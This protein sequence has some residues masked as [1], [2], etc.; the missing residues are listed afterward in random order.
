MI[1]GNPDMCPNNTSPYYDTKKSQYIVFVW[2]IIQIICTKWIRCRTVV[3]EFMWNNNVWKW[4]N[5]VRFGV[6]SRVR[7][8][9]RV[10][11]N[12]FRDSFSVLLRTQYYSMLTLSDFRTYIY[13]PGLCD[14]NRGLQ[15][16]SNRHFTVS[17]HEVFTYFRSA[18]SH[19][20]ACL[21][22]R[23]KSG[24]YSKLFAVFGKLQLSD[25]VQFISGYGI[26]RRIIWISAVKVRLY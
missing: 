20:T 1:R 10:R 16:G 17:P 4:G 12:Y 14:R 3:T 22:N 21:P 23:K 2:V 8:S 13:V 11:V 6:R 26:Q 24:V 18:G 5:R 15:P 7:V 9:V 25:Q 19:Y